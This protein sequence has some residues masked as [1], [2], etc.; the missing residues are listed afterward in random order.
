MEHDPG[1]AEALRV[2]ED[3]TGEAVKAG[4][5]R[6]LVE[7]SETHT[8]ATRASTAVQPNKNN[9]LRFEAY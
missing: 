3:V 1:T 6:I 5:A 9:T 7:P 4:R 2:V 8:E